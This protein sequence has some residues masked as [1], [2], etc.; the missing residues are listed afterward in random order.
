MHEYIL[1]LKKLAPYILNFQFPKNCKLDIR[2]SEDATWR[3]VIAA[4]MDH[5]K[6]AY[7]EDIYN[8]IKD[9]KKAKN[10]PHY[11]AKVRQVLQQDKR[12]ENVEKG[13]GYWRKVA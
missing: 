5:L 2:D 6:E 10:N 13:S 12:Y 11:E 9:C 7:L 8:E 1:V 3:D 4:V